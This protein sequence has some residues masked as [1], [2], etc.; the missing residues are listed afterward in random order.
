MN[1]KIIKFGGYNQYFTFYSIGGWHRWAVVHS[2]L[3][4][5][6]VHRMNGNRLCIKKFRNAV[7]TVCGI[8]NILSGVSL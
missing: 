2:N 5:F 4:L 1:S 3:I 8:F 6:Y 7:K